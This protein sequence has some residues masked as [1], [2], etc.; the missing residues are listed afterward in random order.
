MTDGSDSGNDRDIAGVIA[1][2]PAIF[3]VPLLAGLILNRGLGLSLMP[4]RLRGPRRLAGLALVACGFGLFLWSGAAM[5]R[6]E[7]SVNPYEPSERIVD[8]G[9]F[10]STRNPIYV[11][12]TLVYSGATLL[13]NSLVSTLILPAV[14][15]VV[16]KG[17]IEREEAYLTRKFGDAYVRYTERVGRWL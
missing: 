5:R 12:M 2:P 8:D 3:G 17:V 6:A 15:G 9:P 16:T 1:P 7:T 13:G 14:L 4:D 10:A 11:A